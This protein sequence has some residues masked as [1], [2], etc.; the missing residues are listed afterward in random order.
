MQG[1]NTLFID[2]DRQ[3][4]RGERCDVSYTIIAMTVCRA[5]VQ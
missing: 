4:M 5:G 2:Q 3:N 1:G